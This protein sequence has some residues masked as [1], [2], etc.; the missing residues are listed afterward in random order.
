MSSIPEAFAQLKSAGRKGLIPFIT[1]GDP[2][3]ETTRELILELRAPA[4]Q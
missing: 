2:N 1:A 3:L 4:R